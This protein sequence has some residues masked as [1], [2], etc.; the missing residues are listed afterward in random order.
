MKRLQLSVLFVGLLLVGCGKKSEVYEG[1]EI[2]GV[3]ASED[4][5]S[6]N[7]ALASVL[8]P[9]LQELDLGM[10]REDVAEA[11][12]AHYQESGPTVHGPNQSIIEL[13]EFDFKAKKSGLPIDRVELGFGADND[14]LGD[15]WARSEYGVAKP[16]DFETL[17]NG[18]VEV[19]GEPK[20]MVRVPAHNVYAIL[21][22]AEENGSGIKVM[23]RKSEDFRPT[24]DFYAQSKH[25]LTEENSGLNKW[26]KN[27]AAVSDMSA[28][29][30]TKEFIGKYFEKE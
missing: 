16:A 8:P 28:L 13:H 18:V 21:W 29:E 12:K 20:K 23:M 2:F 5:G 7:A 10:T 24:L 15:I 9:G 3:P 1:T 4:A 27:E 26:L 14:L 30:F 6:S 19:F 11:R 22:E 25:D 17:V